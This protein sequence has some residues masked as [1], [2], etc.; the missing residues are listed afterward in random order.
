MLS[1]Y[2]SLLSLPYVHRYGSFSPM[3]RVS[4]DMARSS[5]LQKYCFYF[6]I[7]SDELISL[8]NIKASIGGVLWKKEFFEISLNSQKNTFFT[9]H[10]QTTAYGFVLINFLFQGNFTGQKISSNYLM[11][12]I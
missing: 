5:F 6:K 11:L 10:L 4:W 8:G 12:R 3:I 1:S 7:H 2:I 9:E